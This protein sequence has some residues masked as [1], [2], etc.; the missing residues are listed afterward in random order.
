MKLLRFCANNE[1]FI[2]NTFFER[3]RMHQYTWYWE[4]CVHQSMIDLIIVSSDLRRSL[5]DVCFKRGAELPTVHHI[6]VGTLRSEAISKQGLIIKGLR[7]HRGE[8]W[9]IVKY[10][11]CNVFV[12]LQEGSPPEKFKRFGPYNGWK[13]LEECVDN[14][15]KRRIVEGL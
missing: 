7:R 11:Y 13:K 8:R 2:M 14:L 12:R 4:A 10:R 9:G 3:R 5:M 1:L 15:R 6:V